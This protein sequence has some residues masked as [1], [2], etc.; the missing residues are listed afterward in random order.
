M[1]WYNSI[2]DAKKA[3]KSYGNAI[4]GT[5]KDAGA[6]GVGQYKGSTAKINENAFND[7]TAND[8]RRGQFAN[9]LAKSGQRQGATMQAAT[10][11]QS[12]SNQWRQR[13]NGLADA[14]QAQME[15]RGGPSLAEMQMQKGLNQSLANANSQAASMR[16]VS[17]AMAMRLTQNNAATQ[18]QDLVNNSGMLR[19]QEQ[20]QARD[21]YGNL[22]TSAR[23][24]DSDL[25]K[26]QAELQQQA[27]ANNQASEMNQRG[28]NDNQDRFYREGQMK[29][30]ESDRQ[31]K[32][33]LGKLR[34]NEN[35]ALNNV[36]SSAYQDAA[37]TRQGMAGGLMSGLA[38]MSDEKTKLAE[39]IDPSASKRLSTTLDD[40]GK[41]S[42]EPGAS[43]QA[44]GKG[45][46]ALIAKGMSGGGGSGG[47]QALAGMIGGSDEKIKKSAGGGDGNIRDFVEALSAHRFKYKEPEKFG[48]GEHLGIMAQDLEKTPIGKSMVLDTPEGKMVDYSK[49]GGAMLAMSSMM[50]DRL[51][52]LEKAFASRKKARA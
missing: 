21:Q 35:A 18:S 15:G 48:E 37:H 14:L 32:M 43:G 22:A 39:E 36:N 13:Q 30:D 8:A 25:A 31:S 4:L 52:D 3:Y 44:L 26:S 19:A 11:D 45:A 9:A 51:S 47:M 42:K 41:V 38:A 17:P 10:I 5:S 28:M 33:D 24:Q 34:V 16:G 40:M 7:T 1:A 49:A 46:G 50:N 29:M 6:L 2:N 23:G 20:A 12:G 27:R